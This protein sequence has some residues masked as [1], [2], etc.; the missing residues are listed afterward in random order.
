MRGHL[1]RLLRRPVEPWR[2]VA[3]ERV[4]LNSGPGD[5]GKAVWRPAYWAYVVVGDE[6][7]WDVLKKV[8]RKRLNRAICGTLR[9]KVGAVIGFWGLPRKRHA[10]SEQA[11][12]RGYA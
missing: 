2:A 5:L 7:I 1:N 4:S 9:R 12:S 3:A 6:K 11:I 8:V 10:H